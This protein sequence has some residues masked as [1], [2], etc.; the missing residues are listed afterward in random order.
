MN[1]VEAIL[2]D[3]LLIATQIFAIMDPPGVIPI[4]LSM[5]GEKSEEMHRKIVKTISLVCISLITI[6]TLGGGY[7]LMFFGVSIASVRI[8]GGI[9][10]MAIAVDMIGGLP[11]AKQVE[12]EELAT[13]PIATPLLVGPGT[14][15]TLILLS[16]VYPIYLVLIGGYIVVFATYLMLRY[17]S[18]IYRFLGDAFIRTLGRLMAVIVASIAAEMLLRGFGEFISNLGVL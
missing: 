4:Y 10:L 2:L 13:V 14:I 8:G 1:G 12:V 3:I 11:K 7:I 16:T 17:V 5:I 15:T 9:I 6:F 18:T